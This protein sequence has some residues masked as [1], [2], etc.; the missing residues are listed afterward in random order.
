M[1][2]KRA[3]S[4]FIAFLWNRQNNTKLIERNVSNDGRP[5][6][7]GIPASTRKV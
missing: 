3:L 7:C 6:G 4:M 1:N 2:N 5:E